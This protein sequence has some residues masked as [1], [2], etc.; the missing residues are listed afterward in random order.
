M[1]CSPGSVIEQEKRGKR[2]RERE[3]VRERQR[4]REKKSEL[5]EWADGGTKTQG[6]EVRVSDERK[7]RVMRKKIIINQISIK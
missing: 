7:E 3:R 5:E 4:E 1:I 6:Q 2:E